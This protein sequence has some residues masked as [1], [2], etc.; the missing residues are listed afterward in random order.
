MRTKTFQLFFLSVASV[1]FITSCNH[2]SG[3]FETDSKT[4]VTYRFIKH[5]DNGTKGTDSDYAKAVLSYSEKTKDGKDSILFD[6]RKRGDSTGAIQLALKKT[7]DGSLEQGI[8]MM[9]PG[10]SAEFQINAD[11]LYLKTFHAP[12]DRLPPG[13]HGSTY[14]FHIKLVSFTTKKEM[15]DEMNKQ[16]QQYMQKMMAR[17]SMES[18]SITA[19]LQANHYENVKP[20]ADSIYFLERGKAKGRQIKDGDSIEVAYTGMLLDGTVFDQ[21]GKGADHG[22]FKLVYSPTAGVIQGWIKVLGTMHEGEKVKVLLPSAM[23]YGPR[24]AGQ[25]IA[26]FTPLLFDIEVIKVKSN[27]K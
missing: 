20:T 13:V 24:G 26:P 16:R 18:A 5:D 22:N 15:M 23:A 10:D 1:A 27:K 6:S 19:Y 8:L 21:S 4:G 17:K 9:S 3:S 12:A 7:F 2:S 11:S 25:M 14:T